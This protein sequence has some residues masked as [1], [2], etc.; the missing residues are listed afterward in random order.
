[1]MNGTNSI[2]RTPYKPKKLKRDV[3]PARPPTQSGS[4]CYQYDIGEDEEK[5]AYRKIRN[6]AQTWSILLSLLAN[7]L[8]YIAKTT[9]PMLTVPTTRIVMVIVV[10]RALATGPSILSTA[11]GWLAHAVCRTGV[12]ES[13]VSKRHR[14]FKGSSAS[15]GCSRVAVGINTMATESEVLLLGD[16]ARATSVVLAVVLGAR[17]VVA[18]AHRTIAASAAV[19]DG[20]HRGG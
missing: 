3:K 18:G 11:V 16:G 8:I 17:G 12:C 20:A 6:V 14:R 19:P 5:D 9:P 4:Y 10:G 1:M 7:D 15:K 2:Y 13:V